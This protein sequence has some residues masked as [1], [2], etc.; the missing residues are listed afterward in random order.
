MR[1]IS[2][3]GPAAP[4]MATAEESS[5]GNTFSMERWAIEYPSVARRSPAMTTPPWKRMA[6]MVV[7]WGTSSMAARGALGALAGR[8]DGLPAWQLLHA[9]RHA[10]ARLQADALRGQPRR[11]HRRRVRALP[12]LRPRDRG[13]A[14]GAPQGAGLAGTGWNASG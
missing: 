3:A 2:I 12:A 7:P 13:V 11:R 9:V 8:P 4:A 6:R 1:T 5:V 14:R 10:A